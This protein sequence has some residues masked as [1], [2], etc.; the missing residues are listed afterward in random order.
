MNALAGLAEKRV[1]PYARPRYNI[2]PYNNQEVAKPRS[3]CL[4][5]MWMCNKQSN[6]L[7]RDARK[8]SMLLLGRGM[9]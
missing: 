6:L 7:K 4:H 2:I 3:I 1:V 9:R 5:H 8:G